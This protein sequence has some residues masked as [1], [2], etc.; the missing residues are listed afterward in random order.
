MEILSQYFK[1]VPSNPHY[2]YY[3]PPSSKKEVSVL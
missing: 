1:S 2:F 3:S